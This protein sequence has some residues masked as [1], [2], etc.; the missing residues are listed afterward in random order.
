MDDTTAVQP[1]TE[2]PAA[3]TPVETGADAPAEIAPAVLEAPDWRTLVDGV[4]PEDLRRHP[5]V[6]GV[7]G[8]MVDQAM[9]RWQAS[10]NEDV[11]RRAQDTARDELRELAR[12]DPEAFSE[13]FLSDDQREVALAQITQMR[14]QEAAAMAQRV[15]RAYSS[16]TGWDRLTVDDHAE[17][18]KSIQ[19]LPDDDVIAVYNAKAL[20]LLAKHRVADA[21]SER[22]EGWKKSEL[23]K[24]R[25]AIREQVAAEM[26]KKDPRPDMTRSSRAPAHPD[27]ARMSDAQFDTWYVTEGPGKDLGLAPARQQG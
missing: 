3:S 14:T 13:R 1:A 6:A 10:Q 16:V 5:R 4:D 22:F 17:L 8:Q 19:G 21:A 7:V 24:E 27:F 26:L 25:A 11:S 20:D 18:A 9:R 12:R 2:A 15:G 23:V